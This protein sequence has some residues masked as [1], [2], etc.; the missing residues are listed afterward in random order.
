MAQEYLAVYRTLADVANAMSAGR[1]PGTGAVAVVGSTTPNPFH[2]ELGSD[3]G[4]VSGVRA[5]K[6]KKPM[7]ATT[8]NPRNAIALPKWSLK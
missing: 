3:A 5:H 6:M 4:R 8:A 2:C 7:M 1:R